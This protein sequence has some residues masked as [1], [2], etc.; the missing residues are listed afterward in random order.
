MLINVNFEIES[1]KFITFASF[2]SYGC[3][4]FIPIKGEMF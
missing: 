4:N 3:I 1:I 2:Y